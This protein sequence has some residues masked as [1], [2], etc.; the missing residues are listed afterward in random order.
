MAPSGAGAASETRTLYNRESLSVRSGDG[1]A[2]LAT[3]ATSAAS[4]TRQDYRCAG[5]G[6]GA[7]SPPAGPGAVTL[8]DGDTLSVMSGDGCGLQPAGTAGASPR[9]RREVTCGLRSTRRPAESPPPVV[10]AVPPKSVTGGA[11][12]R[13]IWSDEF[14]GSG[15]DATKWNVADDA[16]YGSANREDQC[17]RRANVTESGGTLR[18]TGRRE[19]VTGCG[20]NPHGGRAYFFT[21]GLVTTRRQNGPLKMKFRRGYAEVQMRVPRGNLYWPAFWLVSAGDGSSPSWPAYG[22]IDVA[23]IYGSHPDVMESNF[24]RSGGSIGGRRHNVN[25]PRST[26][27]GVNVNPPHVL[28]TGGTNGWHRYGIKWS[29]NRLDWFID[30]VPVRTYKASTN[31]DRKAL[32][33]EKS[34]ML[35]LAIGGTG[36]RDTARGYTGDESGGAYKN[37]NL[38]ADIPGV[39]AV[40]YVRVWQP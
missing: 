23:E 35:N 39:L 22:E 37:G 31:A 2:L 1:C 4:K 6:A 5:A 36:P 40:D 21:S 9:V 34:I 12:W 18:L 19:T 38:T 28:V 27:V 20:R 26:A 15:I 33:Y 14:S 16:N 13:S 17:Y 32:G 10:A 25:H 29:A 3:T 8:D 7:P 11:A 30:G 24:H